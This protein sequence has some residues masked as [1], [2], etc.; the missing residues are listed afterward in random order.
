LPDAN[1]QL[2]YQSALAAPSIVWRSCHQT[3]LAAT[4]TVKQA[5]QQRYLW[6]EWEIGRRKG[7]FSVSILV[8]RQEIFYMPQNLT[9]W[10][11]DFTFHPKEGVLRIFIALKKSID[12][13]R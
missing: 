9:T 5:C 7:E 1:S 13:L 4:I 6:S 10:T 3:F 2:V 12:W 11:C 8:K